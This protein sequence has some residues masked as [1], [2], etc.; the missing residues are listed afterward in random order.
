MTRNIQWYGWSRDL[1]DHRDLSYT[2]SLKNKLLSPSSVDLRPYCP[3]VY[4]QGELGSCTANA[5][6]ALDEF[7]QMKEQLAHVFQPSRL[8]IYY[9]ERAMEG[10]VSQDS[11]AQIRDGM[12][13][14]GQQG[15]CSEV[16][17]PYDLNKFADKPSA[18]CYTEGKKHPAVQYMRVTQT[19]TQMR[20]CLAAG[21]PFVF[22][23]TVYESFES[24]RVA[25][26]GVVPMPGRS[27]QVLGGHAVMAVGY[28]KSKK[29]VLCRNSWG[30]DWGMEGYFWMPNAYINNSQL[31]S[32]FWT[33][34]VVK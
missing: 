33:L 27:E 21:Y 23:F 32:D 5:I 22:G 10:T 29:M 9:N 28:S 1:P 3:P 8:F 24:D 15:V 17:W 16:I 19:L 25:Q 30:T 11:G 4:D 2:P 26:T 7:V 14:I 18:S 31:A 34:R 20:A 6:G 13:S 12:K